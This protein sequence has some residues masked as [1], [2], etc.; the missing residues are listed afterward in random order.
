MTRRPLTGVPSHLLLTVCLLAAS[1]NEQRFDSKGGSCE[2][3][4]CAAGG[5][6]PLAQQVVQDTDLRTHPDVLWYPG[7][8]DLATAQTDWWWN[9]VLYTGTTWPRVEFLD[10]P[11]F[12]TRAARFESRSLNPDTRDG[13]DGSTIMNWRKWLNEDTREASAATALGSVPLNDLYLRYC[14]LLEQDIWTGMNELGVK[15]GGLG[16]R[17]D[18]QGVT[19]GGPF[20]HAQP[21]ALDRIRLTTYWYGEGITDSSGYGGDWIQGQYLLPDTWHCLEQHLKVNSMNPDGTANADA[22]LEAWLDDELVYSRNSFVIHR[23]TGPLP[24][25]INQV[26]GQIFHGGAS[27]PLTPIHYRVTGFVLAKKHIGMPPRI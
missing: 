1:C 4:D 13:S 12:G 22:V 14:I 21:D 25:E 17:A 7:F 3:D 15:L 16:G 11:E 18:G 2:R 19:A 5:E 24:I 23:Y 20:W 9:P 6:P 27:T 26:H 10:V 8:D